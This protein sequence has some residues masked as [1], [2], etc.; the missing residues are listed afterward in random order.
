VEDPRAYV[1]LAADLRARIESG[2]LAPGQ[3][4]PSITT[5]AQE[6]G[7]ARQTIAKAFGLLFDEGLV[8]RV[9]GL[10]YYV[11]DRRG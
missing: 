4:A 5:I 7:F 6:T 8:V 10:G 1:R 2:E 11:A 3:P 9:P